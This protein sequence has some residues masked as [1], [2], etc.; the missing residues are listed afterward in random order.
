MMLCGNQSINMLHNMQKFISAMCVPYAT[1]DD[2]VVDEVLTPKTTR[3]NSIHRVKDV[4]QI[5]PGSE[6]GDHRINHSV[7]S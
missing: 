2:D 3:D 7:G 1:Y 4:Y 6:R 5:S